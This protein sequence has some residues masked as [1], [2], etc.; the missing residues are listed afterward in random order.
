MLFFIFKQ[1]RAHTFKA[2][3][4]RARNEGYSRGASEAKLFRLAV[5]KVFERESALDWLNSAIDQGR[6]EL[7]AQH[8]LEREVEAWDLSCRIAF[9]VTIT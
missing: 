6:A 4:Q 7:E 2:R 9:L 5:G 8:A 3:L 1:G